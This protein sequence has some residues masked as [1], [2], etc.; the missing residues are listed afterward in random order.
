MNLASFRRRALR[1][2]GMKRRC[3][4]LGSYNY[5]GFAAAD[6]YCTPRVLTTMRELGWSMCSSRIDAGPPPATVLS[7][8]LGS[9][10]WVKAALSRVGV[11]QCL[12]VTPGKVALATAPLLEQQSIYT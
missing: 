7:A 11:L 5:L 6:E 1:L 3:L 2:T 8:G 4:N 9:A 12:S 10:T